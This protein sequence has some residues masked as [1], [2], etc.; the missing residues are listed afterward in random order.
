[1]STADSL[2]DETLWEQ[3]EAFDAFAFS[4]VYRR[5]QP[6]VFRHACRLTSSTQ[7]A[8]DV[9]AMV[10]LEAWRRRASVRFIDGSAAGWLLATSANVVRNQ[11]RSR[12][13]YGR[14]L[15]KLEPTDQRDATTADH[16]DS[17]GDRVDME[18]AFRRLS[19]RDQEILS[20]RKSVV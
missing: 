19:L 17:A 16:A 14:L 6:R 18:R 11:V 13:R 4:E 2:S 12:L 10:F 8:E 9:T 5:H 15:Q 20:D 3:V 1:M 7:E